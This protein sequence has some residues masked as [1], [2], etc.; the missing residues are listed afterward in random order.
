V[1]KLT[2]GCRGNRHAEVIDAQ[3]SQETL[4]LEISLMTH[5][6]TFEYPLTDS[7]DNADGNTSIQC[8]KIVDTHGLLVVY[9]SYTFNMVDPGSGLLG[10]QQS[11]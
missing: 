11:L 5:D 8:P 1:S 6:E 2:G 7:G 10:I 3:E 9:L 4:P